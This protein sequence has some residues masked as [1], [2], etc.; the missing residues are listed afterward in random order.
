MNYLEYTAT[1]SFFMHKNYAV[2]LNPIS[3]F[4]LLVSKKGENRAYYVIA[5]R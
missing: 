4:N 5:D 3:G 2:P 1:L